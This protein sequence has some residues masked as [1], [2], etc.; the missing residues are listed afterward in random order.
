MADLFDVRMGGAGWHI[1]SHI[2]AIVAL[3]VACFAIT[4]YI[5]FRD[6]SVPGSA[7]KDQDVDVE[8]IV[9]DSVTFGNGYTYKQ[10]HKVFDQATMN[11]ARTPGDSLGI[12]A[13]G[14]G[15]GMY[16]SECMVEVEE[17]TTN[18][19][20]EVDFEITTP[21]LAAY[22]ESGGTA[23]DFHDDLLSVTNA[24]ALRTARAITDNG[25]SSTNTAICLVTSNGDAC[26]AT[27][28]LRAVVA[29]IARPGITLP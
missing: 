21:A 9:V 27:G 15:P 14:F 7:L 17:A 29:V 25:F 13:Q 16:V 2:I 3:F 24:V 23:V 19:M 5:T 20:G 1:T 10:Y 11:V 8:N 12:V 4:G 22:N 28:K 18:D 26:G 6:D